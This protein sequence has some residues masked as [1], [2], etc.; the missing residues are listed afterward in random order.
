[1]RADMVP[2]PPEL[3]SFPSLGSSIAAAVADMRRTGLVI[4]RGSL[5]KEAICVD[6]IVPGTIV[7]AGANAI[8]VHG[9]HD[10]TIRHSSRAF[11]L[12]FVSDYLSIDT[13]L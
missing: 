9:M 7:L 3:V 12:S 4:T 2:S 10:A 5:G 1:M 11:I 13:G 8:A 6:G